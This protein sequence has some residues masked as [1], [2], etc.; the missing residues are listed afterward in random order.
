MRTLITG[1]LFE[2]AAEN[3][4]KLRAMNE[5]LRRD[6]FQFVQ[7]KKSTATHEDKQLSLTAKRAVVSRSAKF[8]LA[9][10]SKSTSA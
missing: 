9:A 3:N 10:A 7:K 8:A 5:K 6:V 4:A 1:Q 2:Y